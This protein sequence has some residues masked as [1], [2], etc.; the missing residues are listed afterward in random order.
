MSNLEAVWSFW[1]PP[2]LESR[3]TS[4]AHDWFHWLAWGLSLHTA[5]QHYPETRLVTD[6]RGAWLLIDQLGLDFSHVSTVLDD[7]ENADPGWWAMGKLEAY[8]R[9]DRPFVHIDTDVFLW[10]PLPTSLHDAPVFAQNPE[11]I[12]PGM[13]C[14]APGV[15]EALLQPDGWLPPEWLWYRTRPAPWR[16]E[17][18]GIFG[19]NDIDFVRHYAAS[20]IRLLA[21]HLN[22]ARLRGMRDKPSHMI[23]AE[24]YLLTACIEHHRADPNSPFNDVAIAY[25]FDDLAT[26][27]SPG[28]AVAAGYTHLAAGAKRD[29][30]ACRQIES[31]VRELLPA[32]YDR[33]CR[34]FGRQR[35]EALAS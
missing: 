25:L 8:R 4:W 22:F 27:Y 32:Y 9:Q 14:Y 7:L 19:G 30:R 1:S 16:A 28:A 11:P 34:V 5:R 6:S 3:E 29:G 10:K 12:I 26:A 20:A 15:L 31:R 17:C 21:G 23:L 18:C 35:P 13:S 2:Y 33:C 24:Q